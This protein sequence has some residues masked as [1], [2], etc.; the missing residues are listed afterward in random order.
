MK[1]AL[2]TGALVALAVAPQGAVA[3]PSSVDRQTAAQECRAERGTASATRE[4]FKVRYG[5]NKSKRNAFGKCVSRRSRIEERQV[6][7]A[8]T[9][10]AKECQAERAAN[11]AAFALKYGTTPKVAYGNP[12]NAFGKCVSA[13]ARAKKQAAQVADAKRILRRIN[14]AKACA[15]ER[16]A[17]GRTEFGRTYGT[18]K[19][20]RRNAFGRCVSKKAKAQA[21]S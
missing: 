3:K 2:L 9:N 16:K 12:G 20:K 10:A 19:S 11:P 18:V 1:R 4:A 8:V 7:K 15:A 14:A 13:K 21:Q 6:A 5:T 17:E